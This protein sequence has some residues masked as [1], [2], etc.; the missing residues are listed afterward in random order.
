[1]TKPHYTEFYDNQLYSD[2][3]RTLDRRLYNCNIDN[4]FWKYV[5]DIPVPVFIIEEKNGKAA[6]IRQEESLRFQ[7]SLANQLD[8]PFVICISYLEEAIPMLYVIAGNNL[9][10]KYIKTSNWRGEVTGEWKSVAEYNDLLLWMKGLKQ[11]EKNELS[12]LRME[13]KLPKI[14]I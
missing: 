6:I 14:E 13:Y 4:I 1:M 5:D 9:A 2:T 3:I 10:E 12:M 8:I 7:T 11:S